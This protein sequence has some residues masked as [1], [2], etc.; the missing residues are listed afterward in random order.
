[1]KVKIEG[2][3]INLVKGD[4]VHGFNSNVPGC[5]EIETLRPFSVVAYQGGK[6][7]DIHITPKEFASAKFNEKGG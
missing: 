7:W 2:R 1:M 6:S 4:T 5:W 3:E